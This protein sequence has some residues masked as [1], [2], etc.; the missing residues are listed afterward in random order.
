MRGYTRVCFLWS[1]ATA[2][3]IS[4]AVW[5]LLKSSAEHHLVGTVLAISGISVDPALIPPE[6]IP[7]RA[8]SCLLCVDSLF[9][10]LG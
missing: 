3:V 4:L 7:A 2:Y 9:R 6:N 10:I 8:F 5:P 1:I